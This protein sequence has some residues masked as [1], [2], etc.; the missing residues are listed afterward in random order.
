MRKLLLIAAILLALIVLMLPGCDGN[1]PYSAPF[2]GATGRTTSVV[3][4]ASNSSPL[5]KAQ[6]DYVCTGSADQ[7]KINAAIASISRGSVVLL[8]GIYSINAT[9]TGKTFVSLEGE[10]G[11]NYPYID[12]ANS[13]NCTMFYFNGSA[14]NGDGEFYIKNIHFYGNRNNNPGGTSSVIRITHDGTIPYDYDINF[15]DVYINSGRG[16]GIYTDG[17]EHGNIR[18]CIIEYCIGGGIKTHFIGGSLLNNE[19]TGDS[20]VGTSPCGDDYELNCTQT[21]IIGNGA[22]QAGGHG[23]NF[24]GSADCSIVGNYVGGVNYAT[25]AGSYAGFVTANVSDRLTMTGNTIAG[26]SRAVAEIYIDGS[27]TTIS[28]NNLAHTGAYGSCI[29]LASYS[30]N[31]TGSS[32]TMTTTTTY[33]SDSGVG[34]YL[35]VLPL[36]QGAKAHKSVDWSIKQAVWST[37]ALDTEDY[38]TDNIHATSGNTSRFTISTPG[39]YLITACIEWEATAGTGGRYITFVKNDTAY[40][41]QETRGNNMGAGAATIQSLTTVEYLVAGDFVYLMIKQTDSGAILLKYDANISPY[42]SVQRVG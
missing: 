35:Q 29:I 23:F 17:I 27:Y 22:W 20:T 42:F 25:P 13:A 40:L 24:T 21:R 10:T 41:K 9:I 3:V 1:I 15:D 7:I 33:I 18:N 26:S 5:A 16:W 8:T 12:L 34:N 19:V 14:T 39:Y 11:F 4:A 37:P 31:T 38:D 2:S 28:G 30:N 36:G 6:A 32:N